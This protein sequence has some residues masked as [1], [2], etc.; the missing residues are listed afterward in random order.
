VLYKIYNSM[1]VNSVPPEEFELIMQKFS[2]SIKANILKFG[3]HKRGIDPDDVFQEVR[4]KIWK[5]FVNEKKVTKHASY[6][7]RIVN[8]TLIDYLR[9]S[10]RE[11][12]LIYHEKQNQLLEERCNYKDVP[13]DNALKQMVSH[14]V[15]SLIESR[16]KVVK[17]FLLDMTIE[18][19]S[20][21]LKWSKDKTRNLLYRGLADLKSKLIEGGI[22]YEDR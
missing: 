10:R 13:D 9:K 21:S 16:R 2:N 19:I 22:E 4:I 11:E 7:N 6:I 14:A 18:E 20:F 12:K 5:K 1:K 15:D 8:S 3:L 17:L